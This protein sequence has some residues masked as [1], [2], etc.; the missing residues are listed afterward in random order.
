MALW[1][2]SFKQRQDKI[3]L[4]QF[5]GVITEISVGRVEANSA[6]GVG[7]VLAQ[8]L[9]LL[10]LDDFLDDL[11]LDEAVIV[12]WVEVVNA[13]AE[14]GFVG[15]QSRDDDQC[16]ANEEEGLENFK[17]KLELRSKFSRDGKL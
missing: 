11:G 13:V 17:S 7:R 10:D 12:S 15:G 16:D 3:Y 6:T 4:N 1:N 8:E 9:L 14:D 5:L 2:K